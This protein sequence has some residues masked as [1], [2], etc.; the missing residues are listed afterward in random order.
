MCG[1]K[2]CIKS[3]FNY[4]L[5]NN[6]GQYYKNLNE[7]MLVKELVCFCN[8]Y[9]FINSYYLHQN[10]VNFN[11]NGINTVRELCDMLVI[12][13]YKN[14]YRFS[15]IQNKKKFKR[16]SGLGDFTIDSGQH[17]LLTN[18]KPMIINGIKTD[19]LVNA[20]YDTVTTYSV[21]YL[22]KFGN[23]DFDLSS[24][25]SVVNK[26]NIKLKGTKRTAKH[27]YTNLH[28]NCSHYPK[29]FDSHK[30]ICEIINCL[31]FGEV[32]F[33]CDEKTLRKLIQVA[34]TFNINRN[35]LKEFFEIQCDNFESNY[36]DCTE[37]I[38]CIVSNMIL[39]NLKGLK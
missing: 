27:R 39:I 32:V 22:D 16:Y 31:E 4:F 28:L 33:H 38:E 8:K 19:I 15:F 6:Y 3:G 34:S 11:M 13:K 9:P 30:N 36:D 37:Y 2:R 18:K 17:Y 12:I 29:E 25:C 20:K 35:E 7:P 26:T 10:Y 24:A 1:K 21:F 23:I 14:Y 5:K